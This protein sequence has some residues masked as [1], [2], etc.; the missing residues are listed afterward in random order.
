MRS[1]DSRPS[2]ELDAA[3]L[4][5]AHPFSTEVILGLFRIGVLVLHDLGA[6]Q[7]KGCGHLTQEQQAE[8]DVLVFAGIHQAAHLVGCVEKGLLIFILPP[9]VVSEQ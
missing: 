1:T 7:L 8:C 4:R 6:L 3:D 2:V 9:S 5:C